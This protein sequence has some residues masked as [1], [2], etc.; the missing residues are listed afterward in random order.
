ME[1]LIYTF[2]S[3]YSSLLACTKKR[4]LNFFVFISLI[5]TLSVIIRLNVQGD[6]REAYV[7]AMTHSSVALYILREA[8]FWFGIRFLYALM[9]SPFLVLISLDVII[10]I[11][12]YYSFRR[13]Q[14]PSYAY[15][16][17]FS[18]FPTIL[19]MQNILRQWVAIVIVIFAISY[20]SSHRKKLV[21]LF[22]GIFSHNSAIVL[23]PL[24]YSQRPGLKSIYQPFFIVV[25]FTTILYFAPLEI[26][27]IYS[28]ANFALIYV[29]IISF[30]LL[31]Y[32]FSNSFKFK[33]GASYPK[34]V[35]I[36][37]MVSTLCYLFL[38]SSA[39]ERI[40]LMLLL[41]LYPFIINEIERYSPKIIPRICVIWFGFLPIFFSDPVKFILP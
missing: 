34:L 31:I 29:V 30:L 24:I 25:I 36:S 19:A 3:L 4:N 23:L 5:V 9:Q 20:I 21:T 11:I 10:A 22:V 38:K 33:L 15:L 2:I 41:I 12:L 39:S 28:G 17:I 1:I 32:I 37:L 8:V 7:P 14:L 6:I 16:S 13:L 40:S 35:I 18:F 26:S 27:G